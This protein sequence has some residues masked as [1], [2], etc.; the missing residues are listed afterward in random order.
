MTEQHLDL[1]SVLA[2]LS[3]IGRVSQR[4]RDVTGRFVDATGHLPRFGVG[5]TSLLQW[6]GLAIGCTGA[7]SNGAVL[8][9]TNSGL[10]ERTPITL[11]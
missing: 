6:T 1:L 4:S 2:A 8:V 9:N 7:I 3:I 10:F 11:E 5:T